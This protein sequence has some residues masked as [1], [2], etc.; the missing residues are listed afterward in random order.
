MAILPALREPG[1]TKQVGT[2][3]ERPLPFNREAERSVLGA[4]LLDNGALTIAAD[5]LKPEDF[6]LDQHGRIF[7]HMRSMAESGQAIDLVTLSECLDSHGELESAGGPAYLAQLMDGLPRA[8]NVEHY[9]RIVKMK[10]TLRRTVHIAETIRERALAGEVDSVK[11]AELSALR[12]EEICATSRGTELGSVSTKQ[13]FEAQEA[14]IE[15]L[16][17]PFAASGLATVTDALPKVGKTILFLH[18]ILTARLNRPFLGITTKP[19]RV[20]YVSE[21]SAASLAVQVR[22]V[23][24]TGSEPVEEVRWITRESWSRFIFTEFLERLERT[25]LRDGQ[26]NA[27]V[28]DCW[29]TVARLEDENA[30]S[31]VN[32]LG[33]LTIDVAA[34][35]KLALALGRHDRKSG[36]EVGLSGRSSIQL[37]GLV[38]VI[39]H[40]VRVGGN[41]RQRR[42]EILGRVPGLPSEQLIELTDGRYVNHGLP[43]A[44]LDEKTERVNRVREWLGQSPHLTA[45]EIIARFAC[46]V[47][48]VTVSHATAKRYRAQAKE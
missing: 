46:L 23:G 16:A 14:K 3:T 10:S 44:A 35:N 43:D 45:E 15:W 11:L 47:P 28:F 2:M 30:A 42:L 4:I 19:M 7:R 17:W 27:L 41:E 33:N 5:Q 12:T 21:Q 48:P 8:T 18:G 24:F 39:L 31:E 29:H 37:S 36:G 13:L 20:V 34:R 32:R 26:Y 25:F 38:D 6:L 22:E 1:R 40:L 9:A